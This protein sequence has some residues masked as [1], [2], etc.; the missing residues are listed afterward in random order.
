VKKPHIDHQFDEELAGLRA[1]LDAMTK[2]AD[3]MVTQTLQAL[4]N[5][6][7][8]LARRVVTSDQRMNGLEME[9]D[10]HCLK[11]LA[12]W[13][14]A[15]SDLRL[16]ATAFKVVTDLERIGDQCVNICDRV[17]EVS[18]GMQ[19]TAPVDLR[20]LGEAVLDLLREA[21][22]ALGAD[23]VA[24]A[25]Q[26]IERGRQI[27][28]LVRDMLHDCFAAL[29][30][31]GSRIQVTVHAYDIAGHLHRIA[32]HG[33]NIAEMVIFRVRGEDVRHPGRIP[34]KPGSLASAG[35]AR[36]AR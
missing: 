1:M 6:D 21:F 5:R 11:L 30:D 20:G 8:E 24:L 31:D 16:V 32:A 7:P 18:H 17:L 25:G 27:D 15:A 12:R 28:V 4:E 3:R 19:G 10:E 23:D 33:T 13:Q 35:P 36:P 2:E 14:P 9:V 26:I 22:A 34:S 29:R